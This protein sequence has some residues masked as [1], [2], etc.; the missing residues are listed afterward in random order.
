MRELLKEILEKKNGLTDVLV[1]PFEYADLEN[2]ISR[3]I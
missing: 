1:K 3:Y 2:V